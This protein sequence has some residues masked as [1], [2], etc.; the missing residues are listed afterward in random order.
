MPNAVSEP[1]EHP[2]SRDQALED[3]V[4]QLDENVAGER[5]AQDVPGKPSD[6]EREATTGSLDDREP[7]D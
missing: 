1:D 6:R 3:V 2:R 4:D 5:E 7:P